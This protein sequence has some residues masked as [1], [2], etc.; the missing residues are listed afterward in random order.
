MAQ[1]VYNENEQT[2]DYVAPE[3]TSSDVVESPP[4]QN[5]V[6]LDATDDSATD[7]IVINNS[8]SAV[9]PEEVTSPAESTGGTQSEQSTIWYDAEGNVINNENLANETDSTDSNNDESETSSDDVQTPSYYLVDSDDYIVYSSVADSGGFSPQ[10]WQTAL[11]FGR[12]LGEHYLIYGAKHYYGSGNY[13]YYWDY[14]T[15]VGKDIDFD[16]GNSLYTYSNC[17]LYHYSNYSNNVTYTLSEESGT[18]SGNSYLVY[19]D[20]Y[21]DYVGVSPDQSCSGLLSVALLIMIAGLL[22]LNLRKR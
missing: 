13:N 20:L 11:A 7:V 19:S 5:D 12:G 10:S 3:E 18:V 14:Y 17:D 21:F 8:D 9:Q 6:V 15:I 2:F 4:A 22:I 16:E 1:I